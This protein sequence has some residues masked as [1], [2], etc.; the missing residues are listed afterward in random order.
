MGKGSDSWLLQLYRGKKYGREPEISLIRLQSRIISSGKKGDRGFLNSSLVG[1][2]P[3]PISMD[4]S[5]EGVY[6]SPY[7]FH[8]W[9]EHGGSPWGE[10]NH[11]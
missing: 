2:S 11:L 9:G 8:V 6:G 5:W 4:L 7:P 1:S 3:R 10:S